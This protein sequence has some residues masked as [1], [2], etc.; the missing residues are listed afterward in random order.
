MSGNTKEYESII[1]FIKE[2]ERLKDITRTAWTRE[3]R[4]ESVAEHS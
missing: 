1:T 3:G 4:R 2:L